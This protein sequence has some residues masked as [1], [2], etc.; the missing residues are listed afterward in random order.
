MPLFDG[1]VCGCAVLLGKADERNPEVVV[2]EAG[3]EDPATGDDDAVSDV[4]AA[5]EEF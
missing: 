2:P 4:L 1:L 5:P 3:A